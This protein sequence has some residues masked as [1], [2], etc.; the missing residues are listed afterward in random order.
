MCL[1]DQILNTYIDGELAQPWKSRVENHLSTCSGCR[2][3]LNSL[4]NISDDI[5][6]SVLSDEEIRPRQERVLAMLEKNCLGKKKKLSL[7]RRQLRFSVG[8]LAGAAAAFVIVFAGAIAFK[9][10]RAD[11]IIPA[12]ETE[13]DIDIANIMP[14]RAVDSPQRGLDTFTLDEILKNLDARGYDVDVKLKSIKPVEFTETEVLT[15]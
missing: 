5:K 15:N 14:V 11:Q 13:T 1:D 12:P 3:R 10:G 6:N 9:S 7:F 8:Q 4:K 2:M